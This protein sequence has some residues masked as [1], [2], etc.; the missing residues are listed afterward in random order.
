MIVGTI[1]LI[2]L[3]F[4][5][6]NEIFFIDQLEKGVKE[7][8]IDKDR[9]K[10]ILFDLK[11]TKKLIVEF[12]KGRKPQF[13]TLKNNYKSQTTNDEDLHTFFDKL[14][15]DRLAFQDKIIDYRLSVFNKIADDEWNSI[16][17]YSEAS[18]T[19]KTT[20]EQKKKSKNEVAFEKTRKA[21]V[22]SLSDMN[23]QK[24]VIEGLDDMIDAFEG[25]GV[26]IESI[27]VKENKILIQKDASK[28][29]L[30]KVLDE[31]NDL[32]H[33]SFDQL[34]T[35]RSLVK[36]NSNDVGWDSIM[37]AFTKEMSLSTR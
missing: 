12:D 29:E 7:Y 36:E 2:T 14:H 22:N 13:K 23:K 20:K 9:Q 1:T 24:A 4:S 25:L 32:R 31:M 15:K 19:K 35:F 11:T 17:E 26:K 30:K 10:D 27:N 21:I 8:V 16:I 5:G 18:V 28:E 3:L 34:I 33:L 6:G 37:K